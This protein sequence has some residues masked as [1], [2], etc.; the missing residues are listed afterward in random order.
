MVRRVSRVWFASLLALALLLLAAPRI[1][2]QA[3]QGTR[4]QQA[5]AGMPWDSKRLLQL[6]R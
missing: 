2:V 6:K 1:D 5:A 3:W 4:S